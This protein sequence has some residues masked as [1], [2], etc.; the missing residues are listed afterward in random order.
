M[1]V[2][3]ITARPAAAPLLSLRLA[4]REMRAGLRGFLIFIACI[5]LG[6]MAIAGVGSFA[7]SL[8]DG[9][10]REGRSIL[11]GD[12]AFSLIQ[13]EA[14]AAERAFM[15]SRGALSAAA[16]LRA[17]VRTADERS[18]LVELKAVDDAYP[19]YG[20]VV[21]QP[22]ADLA[23]TIAAKANVFGAAA[24][25]ALL[26]R[27][28]VPVGTRV[29]LGAATLEIRASLQGE[30]DRLAGGIGFGPRLIV[31]DAALRASGLVQPGSLIRWLYRLRLPADNAS[32]R[33]VESLTREANAKFPEAGW[34][35][36]SRKNASPQLERNIERFS[37]FLTLV[38]LTALLVGGVGVANAVKSYLE[39][40]RE[41]IATMKALGAT[42]GRIFAIYLTQVLMLAGIGTA[43]GLLAGVALPFLIAALFGAIIPLPIAPTIHPAELAL[44]AAYGI[45][46]ALAFA[47]WPLG[48]AHDVPVSALY[49]DA[50]A[51][52][53]GAPRARYV[54]ATAMII[55]A[56]AGIAVALSYD[57]RIALIF[58]GSS[59]ATFVALRLIAGLLMA[60]ARRLP[61]PRSTALRLAV[62][63][64]HRPGALTPTV[65]LSLGLGLTLLVTIALVDGNLRRQFA[66]ALPERA[67][68]FYF[69]DI[70]QADA[71][72][73][74]SFIA[75]AAPGA[76]LER[77]A[78]L[79]GRIVSVKGV[80]AEKLSPS[81]QTAWALH[82][83]RGITTAIR[84]PDGS[85][86]VA[87]DWWPANYD[88]PP[89]VSLEKRIADGL[90]LGVGDTITVN[91]L[92]R[93]IAA[94]VANLR[95]VDWQSLG[96]NFVLV[97]SP[98][99]FRGAPQT[100]IATL[101]YPNGSDAAGETGLMR[102]LASAFPSVT[103]VRVKEA[104]D[105]VGALVANLVEAVRGASLICILSAILV[106]GGAL[107]ASHRHRVY[108]AVILKTLGATRAKLLAAYALEYLALG[109]ATAVFGVA[110][111]SL[112][113]WFVVAEVMNLPFAWL[114]VPAL[115][116][117]VS[118]LT[119]TVGFG[120][121][122]TFSALRQKPAAI[123]R[124]L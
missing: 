50:V 25:P 82:G 39:R 57:R 40:K 111:G 115:V 92:G 122:G 108:D 76:Q 102:S 54:A 19:L 59:A 74:D 23:Q 116:A 8:S 99:A 107:A 51:T 124:N 87:G 114:P 7:R 61:R 83:D 55:A 79:R 21:L 113:A 89:K 37:Q 10:A 28:N 24:D 16:T 14:I 15:Q 34:D 96:I 27:L 38:G 68:A 45:A 73:F 104:L 105:T 22:A 30:P 56:L 67:P 60:A 20:N 6:V 2:H 3:D 18:A 117:A 9:L 49:R 32:D 72:R 12:L 86:V 44:A 33:A 62:A 46:T 97:Y 1:S 77:V 78:M 121:I 109:G 48:R 98:N 85:R 71:S 26:E 63:N 5:A 66:A 29:T 36:R 90:G 100:S 31:S 35:I 106:L 95:T 43:I 81:A 93:N 75:N 53:A 11:G 103:A 112:A 88:G 110:A 69:L 101:T 118:A 41:T 64:I 123:L 42:G 58:I 120:L 91:V 119:I 80:P 17:M 70:P 65:V 84:V 47:L 52:G 94:E 13:R 4:L